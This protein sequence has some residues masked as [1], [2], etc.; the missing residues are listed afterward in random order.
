MVKYPLA[1]S[2]DGEYIFME[3]LFL[4]SVVAVGIG[5]ALAWIH[6]RTFLNLCIKTMLASLIMMAISVLALDGPPDR[7]SAK[8]LLHSLAYFVIPYVMF[9][10]LPGI[11][12]SSLTFFFR[13]KFHSDKKNEP[14]RK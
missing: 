13:R 2:L 10:L 8:Y 9:V 6:H 3:A 5:V 4:F 14:T 12:A 1:P 11:T 7:F